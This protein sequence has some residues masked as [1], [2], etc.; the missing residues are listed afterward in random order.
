MSLRILPLLGNRVY[1]QLTTAVLAA[2][3][4]CSSDARPISIA[5]RLGNDWQ[6]EKELRPG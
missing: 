6:G 2:V 5:R 1:L 3:L 4:A